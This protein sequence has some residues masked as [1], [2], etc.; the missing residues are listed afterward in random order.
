[1]NFSRQSSQLLVHKVVVVVVVI[2]VVIVDV[3]EITLYLSFKTIIFYNLVD[4]W[5]TTYGILIS[6]FHRII[7]VRYSLTCMG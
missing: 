1:M 2:V 6:H 7:I 3:V 4:Y 5:I